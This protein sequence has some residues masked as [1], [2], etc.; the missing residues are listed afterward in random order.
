MEYTISNDENIIKYYWDLQVDDQIDLLW[1]VNFNYFVYTK[2]SNIKIKFDTKWEAVTWNVFVIL[3]W[4]WNS[5]LDV[6]INIKHDNCKINVY[7]VSF[8][9]D[10]NSISVNWNV[11]V[12]HNVNNSQWHLLEKN[13]ILWKNVKVKAIPRLDVCS[14]NVY[15]THGVSI[16]KFDP[17][18]L[19]YMW[20][21]WLDEVTSQRLLVQ[22]LIQNILQHFVD[23][24]VVDNQKIQAK[25]LSSIIISNE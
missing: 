8:L 9:Q 19:F 18:N 21:K 23:L 25:I 22:W 11:I 12:D 14:Q 17:I 6:I 1:N 5:F 15:A 24:S 7:I 3:Y 13:L 4:K 2:N 16:N 10:D 20:N